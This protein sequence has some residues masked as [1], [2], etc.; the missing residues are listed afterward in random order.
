VT[1]ELP[2]EVADPR[3]RLRLLRA[4]EQIDG[5]LGDE[6][7]VLALPQVGD[8]VELRTYPLGFLP[9]VLA[10]LIDLGPRPRPERAEL[11]V[12]SSM[13]AAAL[14]ADGPDREQLADVLREPFVLT[15]IEAEPA[16]GSPGASLELLDTAAGLWLLRADGGDALLAPT[17]ATR[18]FRGLVRLALTGCA[19]CPV[20]RG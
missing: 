16:D 19:P 20:A 13:L 14:A 2:A 18:V 8:P 6:A 15:R 4:A 12:P 3:V 11:R 5:W 10:D 17:S 7:A 1:R 9:G